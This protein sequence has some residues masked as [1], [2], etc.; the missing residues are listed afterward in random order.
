MRRR[1]GIPL[2]ALPPAARAEPSMWRRPRAF[3]VD[4]TPAMLE[5]LHRHAPGDPRSVPC[6]ATITLDGIAYACTRRDHVGPHDADVRHLD[7]GWVRW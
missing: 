7:G 1:V 2:A 5:L 3:V 4:R 6:R